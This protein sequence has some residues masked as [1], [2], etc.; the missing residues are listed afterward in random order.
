MSTDPPADPRPPSSSAAPQRVLLMATHLA[1]R[2]AREK[3]IYNKLKSRSFVHTPVLDN[4]FLGETGMATEF[5]TIFQ[6]FGW[7]SFASITKLGSKFLIIEFLSTL[8]LTQTGVYF[9]LFTQEFF[10]TWRVLSDLLGFPSNARLDLLEALK[11]FDTH[12]FWIEI[13]KEPFFHDNRTRDIE[14]PTL[15]FLHKWLGIA[16]FPRDDASKIRVIDLQLIYEAVKK[17]RVS[18]V[19][20]LVDHGLSIPNYKVGD[21]AICSIVT[22]LA[23]KL[24][25]I[26]GASLDF[27]DTHR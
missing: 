12:K 15:R 14:H 20:A 5:N 3:N 26:V 27:I 10:L 24:K 2:D 13:S 1:L 11:D 23:F 7:S 8:Q 21:V 6:F 9:R 17:I 22:H 16:F 19:H 4:V 18:P 25:L